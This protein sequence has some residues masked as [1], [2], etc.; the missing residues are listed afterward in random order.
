MESKYV[1]IERTNHLVM[2]IS[3]PYSYWEFITYPEIIR[4]SCETAEIFRI[5][6]DLTAVLYK[7]LTTVELFF[8]GEKL[9]ERL[10]KRVKIALIW[11]GKK[12]SE[13]LETV[14]TNRRANIRVF[15]TCSR[16]RQWLLFDHEDEPSGFLK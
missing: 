3:G 9:A 8:L 1:I 13:F 10:G 15:A 4:Q 7:E 16:A 5:I 11:N 14:A 12:E 6:V 2:T